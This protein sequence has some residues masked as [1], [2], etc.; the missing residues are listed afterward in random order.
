MCLLYSKRQIFSIQNLT[1]C[2]RVVYLVSGNH[3]RPFGPLWEFETIS[4]FHC[5][6]VWN[7]PWRLF[8]HES[9]AFWERRLRAGER[10][11]AVGGSDT[12]YLRRQHYAHIGSPTTW[13]YCPNE[14]TAENLLAGLRAGHAFISRAPDGPQLFLSSQDWMMG[15]HLQRPANGKLPVQIRAVAGK[16]LVLQLIGAEGILFATPISED[17]QIFDLIA[18]IEITPYVRAQI[19]EP[20]AGEWTVCALTNPI[21]GTPS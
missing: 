1:F 13:V 4:G 2:P 15:D 16:G 21:Y 12:H 7:G 17:E 6:E 9:L 19:A 3:P 10:L 5:V 14:P 11:V 20:D 8:N 18:P